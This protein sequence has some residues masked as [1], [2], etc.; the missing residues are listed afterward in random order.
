MITLTKYISIVL[1]TIIMSIGL[2]SCSTIVSDQSLSIGT[3][4]IAWLGDGIDD[5]IPLSHSINISLAKVGAL[6]M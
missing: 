3:F 6:K 1:F 4:N 5:T 2:S